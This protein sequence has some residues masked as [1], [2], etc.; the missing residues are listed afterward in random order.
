MHRSL[1]V[2]GV[3]ITC[4]ALAVPATRVAAKAP[5]ADFGLWASQQLAAHAEQLFGFTHPL[6]KS[7][8][9]P[10]NGPSASALELADGLKATLVS[11]AVH[12]S[13]DQIALWP[14]DDRPTHL[15][16]C[17]EESSNPAVQRASTSPRR[18]T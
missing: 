12:F 17:D 7:A 4:F 8:I 2:V 1:I 3:A 14:D 6:T 16:V 15:F 11:T 9:G 10:F 18:S 13:A 5:K